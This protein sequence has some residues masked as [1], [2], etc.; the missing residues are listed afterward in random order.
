M[1]SRLS[2]HLRRE[3]HPT[4]KRGRDAYT[5][6]HAHAHTHRERG[7]AMDA[8]PHKRRVLA[9]LDINTRSPSSTILRGPAS[10][11]GVTKPQIPTAL[12]KR[13]LDEDISQQLQVAKK[14]RI[15][16]EDERR[17]RTSHKDN[18]PRNS[19]NHNCDDDDDDDGSRLAR[20][21]SPDEWSIF[22]GAAIDTSQATTITE[23]D[24]EANPLIPSRRAAMTRG[25]TR[26]KAEILRLRLG[27]ASYKLRTG[28]IDVPLERLVIKPLD[29][30]LPRL[31]S[32][33]RSQA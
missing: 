5:H 22:D 32:F 25:E 6:S 4:L 3:T 26:E 14:P 2:Y 27:L 8:S 33:L 29:I 20:S 21:Y 7:R 13:P 10:K 15:S 19:H 28:Q 9:P 11:P 23:P 1:R 24:R 31:P 17:P 18:V 30:R 16:N 12:D